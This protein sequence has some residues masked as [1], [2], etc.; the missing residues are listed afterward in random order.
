MSDK[1]TDALAHLGS[2]FVG[3]RNGQNRVG[4]NAM[5]VD[6]MS[7]AMGDDSGLTRPSPGQDQDRPINGLG[8]FP[9]LRIEAG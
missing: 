2:G 7:D 9:L 3:K 6:Q 4:R 1:P 5:I 8:G